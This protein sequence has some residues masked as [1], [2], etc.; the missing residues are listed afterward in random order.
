MRSERILLLAL[1]LLA[2]ALVAGCSNSTGPDDGDRTEIFTWSGQVAP[3]ATIEIKNTNGEV[4]ARPSQDGV[5]RVVAT[6]RG[7]NDDPSSVRIEVLESASGVTIC[8]VYP[9][10]PGLPPNECLPGLDGQLSSRDNDVSVAFDV[11]VPSGR[12]FRGLA[13]GGSVEAT[14]L[15]GHVDARAIGGDVVITTSGLAT[16]STISGDIDVSIGRTVWDRDLAFTAAAGHVTLRLPARTNADV[17]GSTAR[18]SISTDF[19]L[20]VTRVGASRHLQ[21]RLGN[22]GRRL[23]IATSSGDIALRLK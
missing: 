12:S 3:A 11:H 9:D 4:R 7:R 14:G 20:R 23:N 8:T 2:L 5:L 18:G 17:W 6:K 13:I 21:G 19:P 1:A 16:A 15:T 10:V 22:G